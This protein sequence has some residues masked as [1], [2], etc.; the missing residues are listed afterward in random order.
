[1]KYSKTILMVSIHRQDEN[2]VFG[3]GA[4]HINIEDDAAGPYISITQTMEGLDV[5][6]IKIDG[7]DELDLIVNAAKDLLNQKTLKDPLDK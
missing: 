5:G 1:M 7:I 4:T 2:P 3:E 6:Q